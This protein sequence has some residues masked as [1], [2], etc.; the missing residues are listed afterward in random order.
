MEQ[1]YR[2]Q[3][4]YG[5]LA[6]SPVAADSVQEL[7]PGE[8]ER[9]P[10]QRS[11]AKAAALSLLVPGAGQFYVGDKLRAVPFFLVDVAGWATYFGFRSQGHK[12]EDEYRAYADAHWNT[13]GYFS[14]LRDTLGIS[15][16]SDYD[17]AVTPYSRHDSEVDLEIPEGFLLSHHVPASKGGPLEKNFE[18]Y[19]NIGKYDQFFAGWDALANRRIYLDMRADANSSF[20][21]SKI[22]LVF[23]L[24]DRLAAAVDAALGAQRYNKKVGKGKEIELGLRMV[25]YNGARMP[26][27]SAT[28][29]F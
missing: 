4:L 6:F 23:S 16:G 22:G 17:P 5:R 28:Y 19:E 9:G 20:S 29:R 3:I 13:T 12:R 7:L 25:R 14:F 10:K 26:K 24:A 11:V 18:Y 2:Q 27:L 8:K 21:K 1:L 15:S